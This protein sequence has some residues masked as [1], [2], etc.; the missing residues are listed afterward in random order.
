MVDEWC[1]AYDAGRIPEGYDEADPVTRGRPRIFDSGMN[2]ITIRIPAAQK[3]ALKE[4][5]AERGLTV[6]TYVREILAA[7]QTTSR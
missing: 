2:T 5:A 3:E 1:S 4:E 6:S 7:R